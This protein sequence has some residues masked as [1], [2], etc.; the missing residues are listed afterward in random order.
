MDR[1][2]KVGDII[3]YIRR[4]YSED[5]KESFT[6]TESKVKSIY[7]GKKSHTVKANGFYPL[8]YDELVWNTDIISKGRIVLIDEPFIV[9]NENVSNHMK[10][11]T[12]Y[13]NKNGS[14]PIL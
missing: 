3:G 5:G 11:V 1:N 6:Y 2:I 7:C 9:D 13:Y 8:D 10:E 14:Q 4:R 12:E